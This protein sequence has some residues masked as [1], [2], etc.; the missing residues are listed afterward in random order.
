MND[1]NNKGPEHCSGPLPINQPINT[2]QHK[3]VSKEKCIFFSTAISINSGIKVDMYTKGCLRRFL[4]L[5]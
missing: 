2:C 5:A 3:W 1:L 4:R